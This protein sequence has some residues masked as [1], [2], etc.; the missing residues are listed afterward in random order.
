M[1]SHNSV[2]SSDTDVVYRVSYVCRILQLVF[3]VLV[4]PL[5]HGLLNM[6]RA[7]SNLRPVNKG[8]RSNR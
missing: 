7:R 3:F 6:S 8:Y 4:L 5:V 1:G 2:G